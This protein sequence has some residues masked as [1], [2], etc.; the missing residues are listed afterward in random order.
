MVFKQ[1]DFLLESKDSVVVVEVLVLVCLVSPLSLVRSVRTVV[2]SL[3]ADR[4]TPDMRFSIARDPELL[5]LL[6]FP[7][8]ELERRDLRCLCHG[9]GLTV[10]THVVLASTSHSDTDVSPITISLCLLSH[11]PSHLPSPDGNVVTLCGQHIALILSN[12]KGNLS[13]WSQH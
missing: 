12:R 9:E 7:G 5:E 1:I 10:V 4:R 11:L 8:H 3:K 6:V 13:K 2:I